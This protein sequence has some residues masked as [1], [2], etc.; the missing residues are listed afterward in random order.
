M[1]KPHTEREHL[2]CLMKG[3]A[4]LPL[5]IQRGD[6]ISE[7]QMLLCASGTCA[8]NSRGGAA[9][10]PTLL[11]ARKKKP[12]W[13]KTNSVAG[14][15]PTTSSPAPGC[16]VPACHRQAVPNTVLG[17]SKAATGQSHRDPAGMDVTLVP[18][19]FGQVRT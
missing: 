18:T 15:C 5:P 8:P 13:L 10:G 2:H 17:S 6:R 4:S 12:L 19:S 11:S 14:S 9:P 7:V 3:A 1:A 16:F